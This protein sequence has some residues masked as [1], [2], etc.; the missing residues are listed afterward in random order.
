MSN[1]VFIGHLA[2]S[3]PLLFFHTP[4]PPRLPLAVS[5]KYYEAVKGELMERF[6]ASCK[7]QASLS[8]HLFSLLF[9][10]DAVII[11]LPSIPLSLC[12]SVCHSPIHPSIS[13]SLHHLWFS[14]VHCRSE[15][16]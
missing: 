5:Y 16:L 15:G 9:I 6:T 3:L 12:P 11:V 1:T 4:P 10:H 2:P 8:L 13:P 14:S 7:S